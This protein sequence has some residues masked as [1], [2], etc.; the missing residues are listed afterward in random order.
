[1]T[2]CVT[3]QDN[4]C[5]LRFTEW[6]SMER[7]LLKWI[8]RPITLVVHFESLTE[9]TNYFH[10]FEVFYRSVVGAQRRRECTEWIISLYGF[11]NQP[12]VVGW[13]A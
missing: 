9:Q 13:A 7:Y 1:M 4:T 6:N 11:D 5:S 10:D 3:Y 12:Y 8:S 2:A